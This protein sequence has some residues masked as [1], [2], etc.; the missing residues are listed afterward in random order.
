MYLPWVANV[1]AAPTG[2]DISSSSLRINWVIG[3]RL[4]GAGHLGRLMLVAPL[5]LSGGVGRL[6]RLAQLWVS[7][8]VP[9]VTAHDLCLLQPPRGGGRHRQGEDKDEDEGC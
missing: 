3:H 2:Q 1:Y 6:A 5:R 8:F 9:I 7:M 4:G